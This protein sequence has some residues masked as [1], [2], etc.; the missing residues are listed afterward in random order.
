MSL[1]Q[2][3]RDKFDPPPI[4]DIQIIECED[5]ILLSVKADRLSGVPYHEYDGRA[6]IREGSASRNLTIAEKQHLRKKRDRDNHT[7]LWRCSNCPTVTAHPSGIVVTDNGVQK[8]YECPR[9]GEGEFW[10]IT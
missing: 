3:I 2:H 8:T 5:K 7:G 4:C 1:T 10:P 9:C 6:R